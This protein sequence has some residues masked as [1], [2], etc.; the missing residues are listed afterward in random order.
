MIDDDEL[1]GTVNTLLREQR[2]LEAQVLAD[3]RDY[4]QR[5]VE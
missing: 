1:M 5:L 4:Y 2:R 3:Y